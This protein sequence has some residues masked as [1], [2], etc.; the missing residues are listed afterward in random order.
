VSQAG[1]NRHEHIMESLELFGKEVLPEF[2]ERDEKDAPKKAKAMEPLIEKAMARKVDDT[3]PLPRPDYSFPAIPRRM[4][5]ESG[6]EQ[7]KEMLDTF[8]RDR[9]AGVRDPGAGIA[10]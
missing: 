8:E 5:D 7:F 6:N 2:L 9:A 3:P 10:G 4:A 1:K